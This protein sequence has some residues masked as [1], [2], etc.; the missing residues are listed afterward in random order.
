VQFAP[1]LLDAS[2]PPEGR[3]QK[4]SANLKSE[5]R[6]YMEG[7]AEALGIRFSEGRTVRSSSMLSLQA[8]EFAAD[9]GDNAEGFHRHVF[10]A[11]FDRLED[12]GDLDTIVRLGEESGLPGDELRQAL[13]DEVYKE[14]VEEAV[15]GARMA[16]VRSVPTFI[17]DE[18]Y[19]VVGAQEYETLQAVMKE[20]GREPRAEGAGT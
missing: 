14:R 13:Q 19:A 1:Y 11:Y 7:R 8:A 3:P 5:P 17:F 20:L 9:H 18:Q 16:G 2:V 4:P 15:E 6:V 12:I 10:D